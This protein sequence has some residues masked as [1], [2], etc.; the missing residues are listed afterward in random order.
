MKF[1]NIDIFDINISF[2]MVL[3]QDYQEQPS[4]FKIVIPRIPKLISSVFK[5]EINYI[6][7]ANVDVLFFGA[8]NNNQLSFKTIISNLKDVKYV[9]IRDDTDYPMIRAIYLSAP[10]FIDLF[11]AY[12]KAN[13]RQKRA[14][15]KNPID[16]LLAYGKFIIANRIIVNYKP[17]LIVLA[18]DHSPMNRCL[19]KVASNLQIKTLFL[20]HAS[21]TNK[22]PKLLF[23][24]SLLD[25][26]E[27]FSKYG[28]QTKPNG[29]VL[30][31]GSPR[32]DDF[33]TVSEKEGLCKIGIAVNELDDF[34]IVKQLCVDLIK[35]TTFQ[36]VVRPHPIMKSWHKEWFLANNIE[37]SDA[38][39]VK[40][41]TYLSKIFLQISN[42]SSIH[43][44]A[45][46]MKVPTVM[47]QLSS[48]PIEDHYEYL[49][50]GLIKKASSIDE[51]VQFIGHPVSLLPSDKTLSYYVAS[52]FTAME[53]NV[54]FFISR[55]INAIL[56][57][58]DKVEALLEKQYNIKTFKF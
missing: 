1:S 47:Y 25:G 26:E 6:K 23:D 14:L 42:T 2:E 19:L 35:N 18:N 20:Q 32:F 41:Y 22:F 7:K 17:T 27:S 11:R 4:L 16:Y 51:L 31:T 28:M 21:V 53:G 30:L 33:Y 52:A 29:K 54:G 12:R 55:Y 56:Q 58:S 43:L 57:N 13:L 24:Y 45:A 5:R 40:P 8:S 50:H 34:N 37:F 36:L 46:I 49:K 44:D 15:V 39:Q 10:Y 48:M 3:E 38:S 9:T